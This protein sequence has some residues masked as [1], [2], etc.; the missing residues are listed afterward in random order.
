M[1]TYAILKGLLKFSAL[2]RHPLVDRER[3][4][5]PE[6]NPFVTSATTVLVNVFVVS[7]GVLFLI[8]IGEILVSLRVSFLARFITGLLSISLPLCAVGILFSV[9]FILILWHIPIAIA[10]S[11]VIVHE[12]TTHTWEILLATPIAREDVLLAK[13]AAGLTRWT[14]FIALAILFQFVPALLIVTEALT[15]YGKTLIST[16]GLPTFWIGLGLLILI[17]TLFV[18]ERLQIFVAMALAGLTASMT[19]DSWP[20]ALVAAIAFSIGSWVFRILAVFA[21]LRVLSTI[22]PLDP[23][24]VMVVGVPSFLD[25]RPVPWFGIVVMIVVI[26]VQEFTIRVWFRTLINRIITF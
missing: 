22:S 9:L 2:N 19:A 8:G 4:R 15:D 1:G 24:Q 21:G 14:S 17:L 12:R 10:S 16:E 6:W 26:L 18:I 5:T 20:T 25:V 23:M 7:L 3:R 11:T 13:V